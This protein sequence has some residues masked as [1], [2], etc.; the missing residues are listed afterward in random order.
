MSDDCE[1][2]S[3]SIDSHYDLLNDFER[4]DVVNEDFSSTSVSPNVQYNLRPNRCT[5]FRM[6]YR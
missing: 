3:E 1:T 5:N 2:L 4:Y 6:F